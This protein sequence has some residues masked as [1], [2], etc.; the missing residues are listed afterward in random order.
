MAGSLFGSTTGLLIVCTLSSLGVSTCYLLSKIC[1]IET[2]ILN[3]FPR[4][5]TSSKI[6]LENLVSKI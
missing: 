1:G 2:L 5:L 6:A 4:Q 3:Y